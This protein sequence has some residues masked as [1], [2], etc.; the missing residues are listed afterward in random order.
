ME[1]RASKRVVPEALPSL[2]SIFHPLYLDKKGSTNFQRITDLR[3]EIFLPAHV[4]RGLQHVI[5]MPTRD[6]DK[7]NRSRVVPNF[8]DEALDL[9]LDLLKPGLRVWGLSGVHL[10]DTNNQLL[11]TKGVG[12]ESVLTSLAVL[13]DT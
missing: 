2:R 6:G 12:Q 9:L 8:L 11:D 5:P 13:G 4:L 1:S 7:R 10:V 3:K